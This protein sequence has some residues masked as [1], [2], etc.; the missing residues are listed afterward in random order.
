MR[1]NVIIDD[2]LMQKAKQSLGLSTK[3]ATIEAGLRLVIQMDSQARLRNL[4]GRIKWDG[5]LESMRK[6]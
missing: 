3:K 1:T 4:R 2:Q 5:D 6:D